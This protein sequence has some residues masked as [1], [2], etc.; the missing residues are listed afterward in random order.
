[1]FCDLT[2]S[3][4]TAIYHFGD[5]YQIITFK[6]IREMFH[7]AYTGGLKNANRIL[8]KTPKG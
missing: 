2:P 3:E 8:A 4:W 7:I 6:M 5:R 1:M